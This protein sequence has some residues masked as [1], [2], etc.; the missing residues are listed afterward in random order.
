M[1]LTQPL[2]SAKSVKV[3]RRQKIRHKRGT[4][5]VGR[6]ISSLLK[7]E[8]DGKHKKKKRAHHKQFRSLRLMSP[9]RELDAEALT[10]EERLSRLLHTPK[11][12]IKLP[13]FGSLYDHFVVVGV[14]DHLTTTPKILFQ[15]PPSI[16]VEIPGLPDFCFPSGVT[17]TEL[18][19]SVCKSEM[20]ALLHN[21]QYLKQPENSFVF[22]FTDQESQVFYGICV[23]KEE[24]LEEPPQYMRDI[25]V[26]PN[27]QTTTVRCYCL[28]T[29]FPF[30][31]L[32]F[33]F[34]FS[35]FG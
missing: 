3:Q 1:S 24:V 34:L 10:E 17:S 29:K 4:S 8:D 16:P 27:V 12:K 26:P 21:Q 2:A 28:I 31:R 5:E 23:H 19:Q 15:F 7:N 35:L 18:P 33:D 30:F 11:P 13:N 32:H 14:P 6:F 22:L 20:I 9:C 25:T